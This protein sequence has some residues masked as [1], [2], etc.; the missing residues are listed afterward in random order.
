MAHNYYIEEEENRREESLN[1]YKSLF[2][3]YEKNIPTL[4]E[5]LNQMFKSA[6]FDDAKANYLTSDII[7]KCKTK[8]D[9]KFNEIRQK[10]KNIS[11]NDAYIICSYTCE[12]QEEKFSPY[13]I[14]N[15]NLVSNNRKQGI[16]NIS[17]YLY[18]FLK[19]LR[20]LD[21]YY[22]IKMNTYLYRCISHKVS[23]VNDPFNNK[24]IPYIKG[25]QKTF[26][27]FTSTSHNPKATINFLGT[28]QQLKTGTIFTL[29]GDVWGYDI[30]LFNY[31]NEEEILLEP[32]TK[33]IVDSVLPPVNDI[34]NITCKVIKSPLVLDSNS[35]QSK[36]IMNNNIVI[37]NQNGNNLLN[38]NNCIVK[39][40][41]EI[42]I[43]NKPNYIR[44]IG[45]LCNIT[46]KNMKVLI[47][48]NHVLNLECLNKM[49]KLIVYINNR[50]LE[51]NMKL[52]RYKCTN[53]E[54]DITIIEILKEDNIN[55]FLEIDRYIDSKD[56]TN[57]NID[58]IYL[59][60]GNSLNKVNGTIIKKNNNNY[61]CNIKSINNGIILLNFQN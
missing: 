36:P 38:V 41:G 50:E 32:E 12:S 59:Q 19:S 29:T 4:N 11:I 21:K 22:P 25:N 30:T 5:A 8:I 27:G 26:W 34:I 7:N 47:T 6:V 31:Y 10:Y 23:L 60:N 40:E 43:N 39:I 58:A 35:I 18:I 3:N 46:S 54:L 53:E 48:Y 45:Y 56:Y 1:N 15:Q 42:K 51:I 17:K 16:G 20:K 9:P 28:K 2:S 14:L 57:E 44:G 49:N 61:I 24:L 37:N 13:K 55:T 52:L 33:F